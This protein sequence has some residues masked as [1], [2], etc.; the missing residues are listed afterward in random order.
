[1]NISI[2]Y[3]RK[4]KNK[5]LTAQ[6]LIRSKSISFK[7]YM[8]MGEFFPQKRLVRGFQRDFSLAPLTQY[9]SRN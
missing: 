3:A 1:M 7:P 4:L 5:K 6:L 8:K 9:K 2:K